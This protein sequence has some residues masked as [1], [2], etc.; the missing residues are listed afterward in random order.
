[1]KY[2]I[3]LLFVLA[4][5]SHNLVDAKKVKKDSNSTVS[6][7]DRV[8]EEIKVWENNWSGFPINCRKMVDTLAS[9][10]VVEYPAGKNII[11]GGHRKIF[12]RCEGFITENFSQMQTFAHGPV[13]VNGYNAAFERSTLF[14]TKNNC[15]LYSR[16]IVTIQYD[17]DLKIKV[18]K[19]FFDLDELVQ[20]YKDCQFPD[21]PL[22]D[23]N[24]T[25]DPEAAT[26][27]TK[28]T[29]KKDEL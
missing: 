4:C 11:S 6:I 2:L 20:K 18:L 28:T 14:I 29:T 26:E 8:R 19:D 25:K 13:Y 23:I 5:V 3:V 12:T 9:D 1:M 17:K 24:A 21:T 10:G 15:R 27:E 7:E 16:G 22:P